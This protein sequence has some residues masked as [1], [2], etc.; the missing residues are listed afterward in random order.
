MVKKRFGATGKPVAVSVKAVAQAKARGGRLYE[1]GS[2]GGS[3][4]LRG[5]KASPSPRAIERAN[6]NASFK[7]TTT[8]G[9]SSPAAGIPKAPPK[10]SAGA[11]RP[12]ASAGAPKKFPKPPVQRR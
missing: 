10:G 3:G 1:D 11:P 12:I 4:Q 5:S 9:T 6:P 2:V 7:R 8:P